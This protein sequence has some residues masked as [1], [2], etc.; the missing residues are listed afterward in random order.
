VPFH[1][2]AAIDIDDLSRDETAVQQEEYGLHDVSG[3]P[4]FSW[5]RPCQF[6][7]IGFFAPAGAESTR[8][9]AL[10]GNIRRQPAASILS[11][12]RRR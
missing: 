8:A 12:Q 11:Q 2:D 10:T 4:T 7:Q 6:R 9:T 1:V 5:D 3:P